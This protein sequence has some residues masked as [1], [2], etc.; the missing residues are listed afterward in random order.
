MLL[1]V[2]FVD[3]D[4]AMCELAEL[5]LGVRGFSVRWC[6]SQGRAL[7]LLGQ[8]RFDAVVTDLSLELSP[9]PRAQPGGGL[10]LCARI[11][12]TRPGLPVVI[13]TG[14]A[15]AAEAATRAGARSFLVKPVEMDRLAS[16]LEEVVA[17]RA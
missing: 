2:L 4:A 3:D 8:E 10:E 1:T 7:E 17:E 12:A 9:G 16:T 6:T 15:E 5:A 14:D 13:M 11:V